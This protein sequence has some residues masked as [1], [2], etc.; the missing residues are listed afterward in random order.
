MGPGKPAQFH[1]DDE[2]VAVAEVVLIVERYNAVI[3]TSPISP[4][5][6]A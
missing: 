5:T 1:T 3:V 4:E 6:A 2:R